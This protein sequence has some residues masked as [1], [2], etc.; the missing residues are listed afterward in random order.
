MEYLIIPTDRVEKLKNM[1]FDGWNRLDPIKAEMDG[2]EIYF[3]REDLKRNPIFTKALSDFEVCDVKDIVS[4]DTKFYNPE[5]N[6]EIIPVT[7]IIQV[8]TEVEMGILDN[9]G[10][11]IKD[12]NGDFL[13]EKK[14][15]TEDINVQKYYIDGVEKTPFELTPKTI[16]IVNK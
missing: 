3:L 5:T 11:L 12:I 8:N 13:T 10:H 2:N 7:E 9:D 15:I 16:L 14:I 4:I 1:T 6:E